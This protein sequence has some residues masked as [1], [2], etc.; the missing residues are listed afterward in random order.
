MF[1]CSLGLSALLGSPPSPSVLSYLELRPPFATESGIADRGMCKNLEF[2]NMQHFSHAA[3]RHP[4]ACSADF[5]PPHWPCNEFADNS[6]AFGGVHACLSAIGVEFE[7]AVTRIAVFSTSQG[8]R[9]GQLLW[10][11]PLRRIE[12]WRAVGC[13]KGLERRRRRTWGGQCSVRVSRY[14]VL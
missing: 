8:N 3:D 1:C 5:G 14:H 10:S 2:G 11:R 13:I 7:A 4:W 9:T 6:V 12:L